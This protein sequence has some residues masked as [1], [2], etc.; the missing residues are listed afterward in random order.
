MSP[1]L[2]KASPRA[3]SAAISACRCWFDGDRVAVGEVAGDVVDVAACFPSQGGEAT[4]DSAS[5]VSAVWS[6]T[7]I[8]EGRVGDRVDIFSIGARPASDG[9]GFAIDSG[10]AI[11]AFD[12]WSET[13]SCCSASAG[14]PFDPAVASGASC[15]DEA[16][17]P[18]CT[19]GPPSFATS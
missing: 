12:G 4:F 10:V 1:A 15:L 8:V 9:A 16:M 13:L 17:V 11:A 6:G 2:R 5:G 18:D 14:N 3:T 19:D 7:A